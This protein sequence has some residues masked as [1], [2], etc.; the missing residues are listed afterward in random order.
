MP[1]GHYAAG[2]VE[3]QIG[4]KFAKFVTAFEELESHM[5]SVLAVLLGGHDR[6][7]AGYVLRTVRSPSTKRDILNDLL[8][9]AAVNEALTTAYDEILKEYGAISIERNQ[10][11]HGRWFTLVPEDEPTGRRKV[12][13]SRS[14]EHGLA[15]FLAEEVQ[16]TDFDPWFD[17]LIVLTTTIVTVVEEERGR[18]AQRAKEIQQFHDD[19]Q[20]HRNLPRM[21]RRIRKPPR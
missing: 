12:F 4:A 17:R 11:V 1:E 21:T 9:K 19:A 7:T 13:L 2:I 8:Q 20:D 15:F 14:N 18:R 6:T 3:K 10:L 5:S 16:E